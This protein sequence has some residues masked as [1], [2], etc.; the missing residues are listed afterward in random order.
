M[1]IKIAFIGTRISNKEFMKLAEQILKSK[2]NEKEYIL[3]YALSSTPPLAKKN[4]VESKDGEQNLKLLS[5][6]LKEY[7]KDWPNDTFIINTNSSFITNAEDEPPQP[8]IDSVQIIDPHELAE[9]IAKDSLDW[10]NFKGSNLKDAELLQVFH[11]LIGMTITTEVKTDV[12]LK[13]SDNSDEYLDTMFLPVE[14]KI[15]KIQLV[16]GILELNVK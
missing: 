15:L 1:L 16:K 2:V 6:E 4:K 7:A 13:T 3:D 5:N 10:E 12:H 9:T 8:E 11:F 14:F